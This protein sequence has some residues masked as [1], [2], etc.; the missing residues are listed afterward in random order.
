MWHS[1]NALRRTL[2]FLAHGVAGSV[3]LPVTLAAAAD[4]DPDTAC[5]KLLA[6]VKTEC[7]ERNNAQAELK[8]LG[9]PAVPPNPEAE[10][11]RKDLEGRIKKLEESPFLAWCGGWTDKDKPC[12]DLADL[13]E[14]EI[15]GAIRE[16]TPAPP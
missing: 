15:E 2:R 1:L 12:S 4:P 9:A 6:D 3:V 5:A 7:S 14:S 11:R 8:S 16:T 13:L 10:K